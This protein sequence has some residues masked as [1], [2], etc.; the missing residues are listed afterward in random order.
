MPKIAITGSTDWE[1]KIKIKNIIF[2]LKNKYNSDLTIISGGI[3]NITNGV[4]YLVKKYCLEFNLNYAEIKPYHMQ[5]NQYCIEPAYKYNKIFKPNDFY[6]RN[7]KLIKECD[8]IILLISE[9]DVSK[10]MKH[11]IELCYKKNKK[12]IIIN[13]K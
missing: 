4:D 10:V 13:E 6:V 7:M 9:T 11:I 5:W 2:K 3:T 12:L 8:V 1:D